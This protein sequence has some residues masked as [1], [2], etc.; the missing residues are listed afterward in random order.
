M[1]FM[2]IHHCAFF[3]HGRCWTCLNMF[4]FFIMALGNYCSLSSRKK[5][6]ASFSMNSR[7]SVSIDES[8]S[9][10]NQNNN[11][12]LWLLRCKLLFIFLTN[13]LF[14][15]STCIITFEQEELSPGTAEGQSNRCTSKYSAM[16]KLTEL[17]KFSRWPLWWRFSTSFPVLKIENKSKKVGQSFMQK[18][19]SVW[20]QS[21]N[22]R[23]QKISKWNHL[24]RWSLLAISREKT[25]CQG[26][27][28][29]FVWTVHSLPFDKMFVQFSNFS[30][31]LTGHKIYFH[32]SLD[33]KLQ[34]LH[35]KITTLRFPGISGTAWR[36]FL[37]NQHYSL[38]S[39]TLFGIFWGLVLKI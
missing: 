17:P 10:N 33:C 21:G 12:P 6:Q 24:R 15:L 34:C 14:S 37:T 36:T 3:H 1:L 27:K 30:D 19:Y 11:V 7:M 20:W 35:C 2:Q 23:L 25:N 32:C 31:L 26:S 5:H 22:Y 28:F 38:L 29:L 18:V 8:Y 9:C 16:S 4:H 39:I 13:V